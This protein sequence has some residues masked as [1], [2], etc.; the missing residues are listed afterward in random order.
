VV[1]QYELGPAGR[2]ATKAR[3]RAMLVVAAV[4]GGAFVL[5]ALL[6]AL[7]W[8]ALMG[9]DRAAVVQ[10]NQFDRHS[11]PF[12]VAM[13][14]VSTVVSTVGWFV[15]LGAAGLWLLLHRRRRSTVFVAVAGLGSPILNMVLKDIVHRP[16]PVLTHPI[17]VANGWAFPSGHTQSAT[18]GC[19]VLLVVFLPSLTRI[20]A[21][22]AVAAAVAVVVAVALSRMALGV[23]YPSDVTGSVL[24]GA[25]W[26]CVMAWVIGPG[27]ERS[28]EQFL[29]AGQDDRGKIAG[30]PGRGLPVDD[31]ISVER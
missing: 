19:G 21:R 23:H 27:R 10:L 13:R 1:P 28:V 17:E 2:A 29:Q 26:T 9:L 31:V 4:S 22:W 25:A 7:R 11:A 3:P 5:L 8:S 20:A 30:R 14:A 16:R 12:V 15:V 24:I 18:V 6:V